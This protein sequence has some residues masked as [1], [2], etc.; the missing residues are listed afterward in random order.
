MLCCIIG[1][2]RDPFSLLTSKDSDD[3]KLVGDLVQGCCFFLM[4]FV[5][6][7]MDAVES[8]KVA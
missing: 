7:A 3:T 2:T 4:C 5:V 1:R 6:M 8:I